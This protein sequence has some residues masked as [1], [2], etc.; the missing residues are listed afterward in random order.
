MTREERRALSSAL[1]AIGRKGGQAKVPKGFATLTPE[2]RKARAQES[3][4]L[5]WAKAKGA[6]T[7]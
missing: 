5:R 3:A 4:R 1:A 2:E 6:A 7:Q